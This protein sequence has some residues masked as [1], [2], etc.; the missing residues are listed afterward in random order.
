M[1][2]VRVAMCQTLCIS[3]DREGNFVRIERALSKASEQGAEIQRP[4]SGLILFR[5]TNL[6]MISQGCAPWHNV[7][8]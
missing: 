3:G 4:I 6:P 2:H 8:A 5:V 7:M 1:K